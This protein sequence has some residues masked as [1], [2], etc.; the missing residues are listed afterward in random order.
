MTLDELKKLIVEDE[1]EPVCAKETTGRRSKKALASV[2][3]SM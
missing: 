1:A 2:I 3:Y